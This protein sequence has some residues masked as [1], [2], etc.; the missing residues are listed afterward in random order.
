MHV[1]RAVAP[2]TGEVLN[3]CRVYAFLVILRN[4][5]EIVAAKGQRLLDCFLIDEQLPLDSMRRIVT[6]QA[7]RRGIAQQMWQLVESL[8]VIAHV[9]GGAVECRVNAGL[10]PFLVE[11]PLVG[12]GLGRLHVAL[13]AR[14]GNG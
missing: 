12:D 1:V 11:D 4:L 5:P 10:P 7:R 14:L 13:D 9:T 6:V 2:L 3:S 8:R